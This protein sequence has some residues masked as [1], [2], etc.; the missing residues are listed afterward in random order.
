MQT[1]MIGQEVKFYETRKVKQ[2]RKNVEEKFMVTGKVER[3][4][5]FMGEPFADIEVSSLLNGGLTI[6]AIKKISELST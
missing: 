6:T 4:Y 2:G 3:L 1:L 5:D